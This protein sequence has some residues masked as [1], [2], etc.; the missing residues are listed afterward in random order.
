MTYQPP[1]G[2]YSYKNLETFNGEEELTNFEHEGNRIFFHDVNS[3]QPVPYNY[4]IVWSEP[5]FPYGYKSFHEFANIEMKTDYKGYSDNI[6]ELCKN[7]TFYI[8]SSK[9]LVKNILKKGNFYTCELQLHK[10]SIFLVSNDFGVDLDGKTVEEAMNIVFAKHS[11]KIVY[12]PCGGSGDIIPVCEKHGLKFLISDI[13]KK[14]LNSAKT[15][16]LTN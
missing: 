11:G 13:G 12:D 7:K 14:A 16:Y 10:G 8:L 15:R 4:D 1:K 9:S 3:K 5:A 6:Y 2:Y